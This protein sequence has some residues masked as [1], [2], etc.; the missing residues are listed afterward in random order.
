MPGQSSSMSGPS[1]SMSGQSS[2]MSGQSSSMPGQSTSMPGQSSSMSGPSS[3]MSGPSS[4]MSGQSSSMSGQSSSMSGPSSSMSGP[5][6]ESF[7]ILSAWRWKQISFLKHCP[8][9][10]NVLSHHYQITNVTFCVFIALLYCD[11]CLF[12]PITIVW[13]VY[14]HQYNLIKVYRSCMLPCSDRLHLH[15][16]PMPHII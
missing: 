11:I 8:W 14:R 6:Q 9:A 15:T 1:S 3:S 4:S 10:L 13:P 12:N 2:S 7:Q 16:D 5:P